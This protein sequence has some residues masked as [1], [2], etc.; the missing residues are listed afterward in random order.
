MRFQQTDFWTFF[1]C[2]HGW[3]KV[4]ADFELADGEKQSVNILHRTFKLGFFKAALAY[5][6]MAPEFDGKD[7]KSYLK[8]VE[9]RPPDVLHRP[10]PT[11]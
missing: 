7:T 5:V 8:R 2:D 4:S 9:Q 1:K 6:P 10:F 11:G 3:N